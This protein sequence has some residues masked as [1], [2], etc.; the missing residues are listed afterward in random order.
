[1][2][3]D[4]GAGGSKPDGVSGGLGEGARCSAADR[5]DVGACA[6]DGAGIAPAAGVGG[7][8]GTGGTSIAHA[9]GCGCKRTRCLKKYCECFC[10]GTWCGDK[11]KCENCLCTEAASAGWAE[12]TRKSFLGLG[13]RS[14]HR[15]KRPRLRYE[16]NG[17]SI[18]PFMFLEWV[19][20]V[21]THCFF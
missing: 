6:W 10:A 14:G 1:M 9:A 20:L 5:A 17:W 12:A 2:G 13:S 16:I 4:G 3:V 7:G 19:F 15:S 21:V 18:A 8:T 11:C